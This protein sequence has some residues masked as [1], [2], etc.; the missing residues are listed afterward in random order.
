MRILPHRL[1]KAEGKNLTLE[2]PITPWEAALGAKIRIPTLSG[3]VDMSIPRGSQSGRRLRIKGKGLP[4]NP[5]GDQ[6][7][8]LVIVVPTAEDEASEDLYRKMAEAMPTN[9]RQFMEDRK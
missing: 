1:F 6:L 7:V 4:G 9:P 2:V 8:T 3:N 5:P